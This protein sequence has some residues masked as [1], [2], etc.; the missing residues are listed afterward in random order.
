MFSEARSNPTS[1]APHQGVAAPRLG[2]W[3]LRSAP[4]VTVGP[5]RVQV[6]HGLLLA[7][8]LLSSATYLQEA[9]ASVE[10]EIPLIIRKLTVYCQ[11]LPN[12]STHSKPAC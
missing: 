6:L 10:G 1:P 3:R 4:G 9:Y 12:R 7:D 5:F 11:K 8:G 2:S